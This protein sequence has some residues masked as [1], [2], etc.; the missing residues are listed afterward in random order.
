MQSGREAVRQ[1]GLACEQ[2][3]SDNLPLLLSGISSSFST[4]SKYVKF[5]SSSIG[6]KG[7][8]HPSIIFER[9]CLKYCLFEG[10]GQEC[11][12]CVVASIPTQV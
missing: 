10:I 2:K 12:M 8:G 11:K 9:Y 7:G 1:V 3:L 6:T 5:F 4:A